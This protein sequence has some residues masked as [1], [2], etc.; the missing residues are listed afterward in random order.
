MKTSM[1]FKQSEFNVNPFFQRMGKLEEATAPAPPKV[2]SHF[3]DKKD[4]REI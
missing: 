3:H 2:V 1:I 4:F